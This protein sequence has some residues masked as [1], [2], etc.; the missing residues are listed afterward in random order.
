[1]EK[2]VLGKIKSVDI[3]QE[4]GRF[5]IK[6][7]LSF[8]GGSSGVMLSDTVW[9]PASV[10]IT[11]NTTW[12][13]NERNAEIIKIMKKLDS[14]MHEAKVTTLQG[15]VDMPIEAE[16]HGGTVSHWRILTEVL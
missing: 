4:D 7:E 5:G 2:T 1:M 11:D 16:Q 9:S 10:E 8:G 12:T 15:L 13:E 6:W 14:L 3:Y